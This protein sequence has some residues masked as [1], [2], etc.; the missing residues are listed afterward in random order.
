MLVTKEQQEIL[1][2]KYL[3]EN[4]NSNECIGFIDGIN[5][6]LELLG[7]IEKQEQFKCPCC[8]SDNVYK[9]NAYHCN[10]CAVTTEI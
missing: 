9:T 3:K 2:H 10:R 6:T 4:H 8:G 5:A 7:R 1:I